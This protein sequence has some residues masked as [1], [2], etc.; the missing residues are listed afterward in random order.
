MRTFNRFLAAS[1]SAAALMGALATATPAMADEKKEAKKDMTGKELAFD[2]G[3]GN[4]LSC[5]MIA[6]GDQ[7]GTIAPPLVAMK[8]R[9]PDRAAL[10]NVIWDPR[11]KFGPGTIMPPIG[12]HGILSKDEVEKVVDFVHSL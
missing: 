6:G 5:H 2:R 8:A 4:C 10:Y 9:Y 11:S 1:V 12:A 3:K 7:P